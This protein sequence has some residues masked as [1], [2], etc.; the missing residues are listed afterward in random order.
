VNLSLVG[1][2]GDLHSD[3][4]FEFRFYSG[5]GEKSYRRRSDGRRAW[6]CGILTAVLL[7]YLGDHFASLVAA[8]GGILSTRGNA[9]W[10]TYKDGAAL[11]LPNGRFSFRVSSAGIVNSLGGEGGMRGPALIP[12]PHVSDPRS[13]H[14]TM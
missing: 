7:A 2:T 3:P 1:S 12:S 11:E 14:Q 4:G 9:R 8:Y 5:T 6:C 13:A 10:H